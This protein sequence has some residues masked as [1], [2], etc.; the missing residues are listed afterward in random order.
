L[1]SAIIVDLSMKAQLFNLCGFDSN[2]QQWDLLYRG[3]LHGFKSS[4]F[5]EKCDNIAKTLT[6]IRA[7]S[8]NIFGGFTEA[9]WDQTSGN[10]QDNNAFLFS[11]VNSDNTPVKIE[12][13]NGKEREAIYCDVK[14]GPTFGTDLDIIDN[15]NITNNNVSSIGK[16]YVLANFPAGS[17]QAK[18]LL[19]GSHKFRVEEIEVFTQLY[20]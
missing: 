10:K 2:Q 5:H 11:L 17:V 7:T 15:S 13:A 19:A 1:E 14:Y 4:N 3:S 6:I 18:S 12:I 9:T 8:G 20:Y 16:S